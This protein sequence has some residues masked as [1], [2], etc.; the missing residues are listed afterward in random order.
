MSVHWLSSFVIVNSCSCQIL[1]W[2]HFARS[3]HVMPLLA[4]WL[5]IFSFRFQNNRI[6][7]LHLGSVFHSQPLPTMR[8]NLLSTNIGSF[9]V[10]MFS[11]LLFS[12]YVRFDWLLLKEILG[13][14]AGGLAVSIQ[15]NVLFIFCIV[16]FFELVWI[17]EM[18]KKSVWV[19]LSICEYLSIKYIF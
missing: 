1:L 5:L 2:T 9:W 13:A 19:Y 17:N 18:G 3:R 16:L 11:L 10:V 14:G 6:H 4:G 12:P 15:C 7:K 8:W